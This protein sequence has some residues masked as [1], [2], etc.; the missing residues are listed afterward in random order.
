M[1]IYV[2]DW[3]ALVNRIPR[4]RRKLS[5]PPNT[6]DRE[7]AMDHS[8]RQFLVRESRVDDHPRIAPLDL[9]DDLVTIIR[10]SDGRKWCY[11]KT[12]RSFR[13][14]FENSDSYALARLASRERDLDRAIA[15][16]GL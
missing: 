13:G 8:R 16:C 1:N 7:W 4:N 6:T 9:K 2:D 5:R 10:L 11:A 3:T 15:W 14:P 12:T